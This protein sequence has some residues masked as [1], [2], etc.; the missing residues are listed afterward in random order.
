MSQTKISLMEMSEAVG[1]CAFTA[2]GHVA[3]W[4][5]DHPDDPLP[6]EHQWVVDARTLET[7]HLVFSM[8]ALRESE[9]RKLV[10]SIRGTPEGR[11]LWAMM[12]PANPR[13][14]EAEAA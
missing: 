9:V 3:R 13:P 10:A 5:R 14:A 12:T 8:L 7:A 1:E 4:N 2:R 6:P 11:Q